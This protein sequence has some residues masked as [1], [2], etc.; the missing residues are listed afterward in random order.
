MNDYYETDEVCFAD[1]GV[2]DV[3]FGSDKKVVS[4]RANEL[5]MRHGPSGDTYAVAIL[6][7]GTELHVEPCENPLWLRA[8]TKNGRLKGYVLA[9]FVG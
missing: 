3:T 4:V 7:K 1:S 6:D 2:G 9:S 8:S 5:I